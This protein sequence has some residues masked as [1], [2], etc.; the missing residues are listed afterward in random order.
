MQKKMWSAY[1]AAIE[2]H[3]GSRLSTAEASKLSHLLDRL[4]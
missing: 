3:V 1:A 2:R 4:K